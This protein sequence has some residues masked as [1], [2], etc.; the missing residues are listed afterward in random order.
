MKYLEFI[1]PLIHYTRVK[2]NL[3]AGTICINS[4]IT[5][6]NLRTI[7][8]SKTVVHPNTLKRVCDNTGINFVLLFKNVE[9]YDELFENA[10]HAFVYDNKEDQVE[11]MSKIDSPKIETSVL[12]PKFLLIQFFDAVQNKNDHAKNEELVAEIEKFIHVYSAAE[13]CLYYDFK[14]I[15]YANILNFEV[16]DECF[17]IA[18]EQPTQEN[19]ELLY[20]HLGKSYFFKHEF[21]ITLDY[22]N[23]AYQLFEKKWNVNRLLY[24]VGTIG[25]CYSFIGSL[26]LAE[27]QYYK[28][29]KMSK[30]YKNT[31]ATCVVYDNIAYNYL[32]QRKYNECIDTV[33]LAQKSGSEYQFLYFYRA[34]SLAKIGKSEDALLSV[35]KAKEMN[36]ESSDYKFLIYVKK[37]IKKDDDID[38]Y[39]EDLYEFL[40]ARHEYGLVKFLLQDLADIHH[41]EERFISEISCLKRIIK[42]SQ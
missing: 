11:Y 37:M 2:N 32:L 4:H 24:T 1:G 33:K 21:L 19:K 31:Y 5:R 28:A 30:K 42:L 41:G 27:K 38:E 40:I 25:L 36:K 10:L 12:Y 17:K 35:E 3:D 18:E 26:D 20:Y 22:L 8:T 15:Y 29:L 16:S 13:K 23:K 39:L 9:K 6:A 14:G 7:E 34:Y